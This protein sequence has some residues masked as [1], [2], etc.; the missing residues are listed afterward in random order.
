MSTPLFCNYTIM[1][2][3]IV[4]GYPRSGKDTFVDMVL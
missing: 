4:N 2:I 3:F 1:K